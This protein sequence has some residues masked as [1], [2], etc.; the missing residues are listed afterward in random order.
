MPCAGKLWP[1]PCVELRIYWRKRS[2]VQCCAVQVD[3]GLTIRHPAESL[4]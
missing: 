2:A 1:P 3:I 4:Q